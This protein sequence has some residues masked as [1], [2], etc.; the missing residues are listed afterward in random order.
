MPYPESSEPPPQSARESA[1]EH[2]HIADLNDWQFDWARGK[3]DTIN[4]KSLDT[5]ANIE[6]YD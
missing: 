2:S 5:V 3:I 1:W 6:K 4:N